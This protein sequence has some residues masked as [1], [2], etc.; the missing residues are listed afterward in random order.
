M[1]ALRPPPR[2][3][4]RVSLCRV[5]LGQGALV[6]EGPCFLGGHAQPLMQ[7]LLGMFTEPG[8]RRRRSHAPNVELH[9]QPVTSIASGGSSIQWNASPASGV[10]TISLMRL[11][12]SA[13]TPE[14]LRR[15]STS[16]LEY[17]LDQTS[18]RSS[19]SSWCSN[20]PW[21]SSNR[22]AL[23]QSGYLGFG[24]RPAIAHPSARL[25]C[26]SRHLRH[27]GSSPEGPRSWSGRPDGGGASPW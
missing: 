25:R 8:C 15:R 5:R 7:R 26:T 20:R 18:R 16:M 27:N 23:A 6:K 4:R 13:G 10:P 19:N 1:L 22:G 9:G 12:R 24:P 2:C 14:A 21:T 3:G 11:I 17:W